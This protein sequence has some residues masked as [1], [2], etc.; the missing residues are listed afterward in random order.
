[1][2]KINALDPQ[3]T[4]PGIDLALASIQRLAPAKFLDD[5]LMDHL[6]RNS[7]RR[8]P[9]VM[10]LSSQFCKKYIQDAVPRK[11]EASH[12]ES[13]W[14]W[15]EFKVRPHIKLC[16][17]SS[18]RV[19]DANCDYMR[20]L[21]GIIM[22]VNL[23]SSKHW[24]LSY[25]DLREKEISVMDSLAPPDGSRTQSKHEKLLEVG[26]LRHLSLCVY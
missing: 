13:A 10:Y 24:L 9:N 2:Q 14:K 19:Q 11:N 7:P 4:I 6:I 1:M 3:V 15:G 23:P 20:A 25:V 8:R 18:E 12:W 21:T 17:A 16:P 22:P 26:T 5:G